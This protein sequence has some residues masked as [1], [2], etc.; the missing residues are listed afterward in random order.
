MTRA[1]GTGSIRWRGDKAYLAFTHPGTGAETM[2]RLYETKPQDQR[3]RVDA[4]TD[5]HP[6]LRPGLTG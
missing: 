4:R 3:E 6:T 2:R 5:A 1:W